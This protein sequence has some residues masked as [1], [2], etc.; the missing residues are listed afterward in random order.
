M[1]LQGSYSKERVMDFG[2]FSFNVE[3]HSDIIFH[4]VNT[5]DD[6]HDSKKLIV[7]AKCHRIRLKAMEIF[8]ASLVHIQVVSGISASHH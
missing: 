3:F 5:L 6:S 4:G 7:Q 2:L 1:I 8:V